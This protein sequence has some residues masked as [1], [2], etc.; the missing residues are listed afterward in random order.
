[1][2]TIGQVFIPLDR[3]H[4]GT[5]GHVGNLKFLARDDISEFDS[6]HPS[7][8]RGSGRGTPKGDLPGEPTRRRRA[9]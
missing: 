4:D 5:V 2:T 9:R 7:I 8:R 3:K 6:S 1:M